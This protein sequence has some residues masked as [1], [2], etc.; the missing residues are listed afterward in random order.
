MASGKNNISISSLLDSSSTPSSQPSGQGTKPTSS[1]SKST[2]N[3]GRKPIAILEM[4]SKFQT[5][6]NAGPV[7]SE[8]IIIDDSQSPRLQ[9]RPSQVQLKCPNPDQNQN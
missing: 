4:V 3:N 6:F 5:S 2:V 8:V 9:E 7:E 1:S